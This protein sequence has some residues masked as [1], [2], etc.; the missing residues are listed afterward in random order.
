M[1][2]A[3]DRKTL[4]E[5]DPPAWGEPEYSSH[6]VT[7]CHRLRKKPI[8]SFT[9]EELRIMIGQSIGLEHLIPRA[10][11]LLEADPLTAGDY[12]PGD[13]LQNVLSV[14]SK[15][16]LEH[17]ELHRRAR[18]ILTPSLEARLGPSDGSLREKIRAFC[19]T[20]GPSR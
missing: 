2:K 17:R 12:F 8:G 7:T 19:Q 16:W 1:P 3:H 9:A 15:F 4:D 11:V 13:L 14:E 10:L 18:A 5:L 20:E 6:L